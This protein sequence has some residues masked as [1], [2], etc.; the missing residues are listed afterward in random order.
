MSRLRRGLWFLWI[1]V[2]LSWSP[3][4]AVEGLS[5]G[6]QLYERGEQRQDGM[7]LPLS[8]RS[9]ADAS[10]VLRGAAVACANC[11]GLQ[12][13]GG[14]EGFQRI[15]GL[16]WSEWSSPDAA[17][18]EAAFRRFER[19]VRNGQGAAGKPLSA[20]MPRF[21]ISDDAVQALA[22]H[23]I[24]LTTTAPSIPVPTLALLRQQD[25]AAPALE[26]AV[27]QRLLRCLRERLGARIRL[28]VLDAESADQA[29]A[30]WQRL[31]LRSDVVAALA[32][33]WRGWQPRHTEAQPR[34][35]A[36][37][38]LTA[39]P[40]DDAEAVHWL[41]GGERARAVALALAWRDLSGE[42]RLPVWTGN[43]TEAE[44][45]WRALDTLA[46]TVSQEGGQGL[47][48]ERLHAPTAPAGRAAL[49]WDPQG[50][51]AAGWWLMPEPVR[52]DPPAGSRWWMAQPYPG[53]AMRPLAHRWADAT[54]MTLEAVLARSP[55]PTRSNWSQL[56]FAAGR[57]NDGQGWHWRVPV[58]DRAG[59]GAAT[60]W[61][62]VEFAGSAPPRLVTPLVEVGGP[63]AAPA[64]E[65]RDQSARR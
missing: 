28:E 54:C 23:V 62:V 63:A 17:V 41:F 22:A 10:W 25:R 49:W 33:A 38:P 47:T 59:F 6:A 39:D 14:G 9:G 11:H 2:A 52:A 8:A 20:A 30:H 40:V 21:D 58:Q 64:D 4:R 43:G 56:L 26:Q 50:L 34:L 46:Q 32:P 48:F 19:A 45:R 65:E 42:R 18:R 57:L 61:S 55:T 5:A 12:A 3:A 44:R 35:P 15:P 13:Q 7:P 36:L 16:R 29:Q 60:G 31:A 53:Q 51:P 24:Q 27:H 1:G 37:F